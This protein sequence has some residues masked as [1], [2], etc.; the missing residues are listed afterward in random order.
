ME[1][2]NLPTLRPLRLGELLD[3]AI[4]LYR[5][6]FLTFIGIIAVVYVPLTILQTAASTL[7]SSLSLPDNF[8]SPESRVISSS[9]GTLSIFILM[10]AQ[11]ILV[12]GV[13]AGALTRAVA[14]SYLG[15][16]TGIL[17]AYQGIRGSWLGLI[18]ALLLLGIITI[19][20]LIWWIVPCIGWVTGMGM[21]LFV[22]TVILPLVPPVI[23]LEH[24]GAFD[25]L[26]RAWSLARR[27]FWPIL[28]CIFIL[29]L[30][31]W[32]VVNGPAL[33]V[34]MLLQQVPQSMGD[35]TM[36]LILTSTVQGLVSLVFALFYL[37]L[38]MTAIALLYF[39]VRVRTE[40]FDLAIL[41][42]Q[43]SGATDLSGAMQAPVPA[44]E[45][46]VTWAE[47]GNF[48]ILTLAGA[49]LYIFFF[50]IVGASALR[51]LFSLMNMR[52]LLAVWLIAFLSLVNL[53]ATG[54]TSAVCC[55]PER[56]PI[57]FDDYWKLVRDTRQ[58]IAGLEAKPEG[59]IRQELNTLASQWGQVTAVEYSDQSVIQIDSSYLA[60]ELRRNPPDLQRLEKEFEALLQAHEEY[61]R[62]VFTLEDVAPLKENSGAAQVPMAGEAACPDAGT[63]EQEFLTG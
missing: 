3:R 55:S 33:I 19:G 54:Q 52:S 2:Q 35:S 1:N 39:D 24:Q 53:S 14:D 34:S 13:A 45:R 6:N 17:D 51:F 12:Q 57:P 20:I 28:G 27:R 30:F 9:I 42:L 16:K 8:S 59:T 11:I 44:D 61:P 23:V 50:S 37:P 63:A 15:R 56:A 49:G 22:L 43:A 29:Y 21:W 62:Q 46:L 41:A 4:R 26:R 40:G 25:A 48:A 10:F 38:Q 58:A 60:A 18:G 32:I 36:Q 7:I 47:M 5:G 31:S